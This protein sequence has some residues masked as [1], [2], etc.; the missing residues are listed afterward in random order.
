MILCVMKI[1]LED[2]FGEVEY[3]LGSTIARIIEYMDN[4]CQLKDKY[5]KR[6]DRFFTFNDQ[7]NCQRVYETIKSLQ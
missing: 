7:K 4:G 6:I 5:R 2:G 1:I 3:N